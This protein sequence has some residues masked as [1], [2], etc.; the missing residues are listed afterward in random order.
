MTAAD[1]PGADTAPLKRSRFGRWALDFAV[2]HSFSIGGCF[3]VQQTAS[4]PGA[5]TVIG[6]NLFLKNC[7]RRHIFS[8]KDIGTLFAYLRNQ[9]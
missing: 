3:P 2:R 8:L 7:P 4:L 1:F 9:K 5:G 6:L